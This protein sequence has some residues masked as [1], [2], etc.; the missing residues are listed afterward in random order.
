MQLGVT[1]VL[2]RDE[3]PPIATNIAKLPAL[4]VRPLDDAV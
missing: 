3:S 2:T 4:L 1:R